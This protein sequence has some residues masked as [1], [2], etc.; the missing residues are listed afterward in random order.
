MT[1]D[2][3]DMTSERMLPKHPSIVDPVVEVPVSLKL[4]ANRTQFVIDRD[5]VERKW[6][7]LDAIVDA[8]L[9]DA[10]STHDESAFPVNRMFDQFSGVSVAPGLVPMAAYQGGPNSYLRFYAGEEGQKHHFLTALKIDSSLDGFV[11]AVYTV[12]VL[13]AK[14]AQ[15]HGLYGRDY[16]LIL[17]PGQFTKPPKRISF[18]GKFQWLADNYYSG[19]LNRPLGIR[20]SKRRDRYYVSCMAVCPTGSVID[21]TVRIDRGDVIFIQPEKL[22]ISGRMYCY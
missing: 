6:E 21:L 3:P 22:F 7:T 20:V 9:D 15:W 19:N 12:F 10:I 2:I 4:M 16:E 1:S 17:D 13:P 18:G 8:F 5:M 11:E 14:R